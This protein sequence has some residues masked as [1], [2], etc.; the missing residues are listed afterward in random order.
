M[1]EGIEKPLAAMNATVDQDERAGY[2]HEIS[3]QVLEQ[4][5]I[6]VPVCSV[7][8]VWMHRAE[9]DGLQIAVNYDI[10]WTYMHFVEDK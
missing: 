3:K 10:D 1:F 4:G 8:S 9:L 6:V 5:S 7:R 2:M